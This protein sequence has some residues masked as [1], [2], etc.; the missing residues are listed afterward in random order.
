MSEPR[1][2][3]ELK[4]L[5]V[6]RGGKVELEPFSLLLHAGETVVLL[7]EAG[8]GKDAVLRTLGGF[9]E[10]DEEAVGRL[11]V[12]DGEF[13]PVARRTK[14]A[15]RTAYLPSA[16]GNALDPRMSAAE[17]LSRV[18]AR[19][20]SCPKPA[21]LEELRGALARF[22]AAPSLET[23]QAPVAR[24][25][26]AAVAFG[27]LAAAAAATPELLLCDHPMADLS[28]L[29]A[30]RVTRALLEEQTRQGFAIVYCARE[31]HPVV[32]LMART[33]VLRRGQVV[34]EGSA[35][36]L[37]GGQTH[38]YTK[39]IF[40]ALP[41]D[42]ARPPRAASRG[43]PLLQVQNLMLDAAHRR[44]DA[45][46]F[47]LRRGAAMGLVGEPGSGRRRLLDA[48]LGLERRPG[49]VVF[50]AVDLNLLSET[51]ALRLRRRVAFVTSRDGALDPRMSLWDTVDEPLR[52][53]L[54]LSRE[55]AS[56]YRDNALKRVGLASHDGRQAVSSLSPFDRRRLQIARAIVAAPLLV[57]VDEPLRALDAPAQSTIRDLLG[58]FRVESQAGFLVLTS[59]FSVAAALCD[60][61]LVFDKGRLVERGPIAT[62]LAAPREAATKALVE[63]ATLKPA[64]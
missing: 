22:D 23:I 38:P 64:A 13:Q 58:E 59:D 28:P 43:E 32:R 53:H 51:M 57:V 14:P 29:A 4:D 40:K 11:R 37:I 17:Q 20:L 54:N 52:A 12:G 15:L 3:L 49:R 39:S 1:V 55:L 33:I 27:L 36:H 62:L 9:F 50:D 60:D 19:K 56:D 24:L 63:A 30:N 2:L 25:E 35:A 41:A 18:L 7:G 8:S 48:V 47:E 10:R 16:T 61:A 45:I 6:T 21:A 44:R 34:E 31:P 26:P 5:R 42:L 46:G